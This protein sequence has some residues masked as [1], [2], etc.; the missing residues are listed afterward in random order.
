MRILQSKIAWL[1]FLT[2]IFLAGIGS[3][4]PCAH[5]RPA[6]LEDAPY[7]VLE[8]RVQIT[9]DRQGRSKVRTDITWEI[10]KEEARSLFS[11][12]RFVYNSRASRFRIIRAEAFAPGSHRSVAVPAHLIQD[13]PLASAR[14][15]F[16]QQNQVSVAFP[17]IEKGSQIHIQYEENHT[18]PP[19]PGSFSK[20]FILGLGELTEKTEIEISSPHL[21]LYSAIHDPEGSLVIHQNTN[22]RIHLSLKKPVFFQPME[23]PESLIEGSQLIWV[24][25]SSH[26]SWAPMLQSTLPAYEARLRDPLPSSLKEILVLLAKDEK[27]KIPGVDQVNLLMA[28]LSTQFHYFGDWRPIR[29]GHIP[30]PLKT[31][32]ETRFGDCKDLSLALAALLRELGYSAHLAWIQR[33]SRPVFSPHSLPI[34]GAFN[35]AIVYAQKDGR[36]FWLDPTNR[37]SFA[38]GVFEDI[39]DRPAL[40]LD[41]AQP[42]LVRTP[43]ALA[44]GSQVEFRSEVRTQREDTVTR[45]ELDLQGR[46]VLPY[47][48]EELIRSQENISYRLVSRFA[49]ESRLAEWKV[50]PYSL[51]ERIARP[52]SFSFGFKEMGVDLQTSEGSAQVLPMAPGIRKFLV[53]SRDRISGLSVGYPLTWVSQTQV[54]GAKSEGV[55]QGCEIRS[56]WA[57]LVRSYKRGKSDARVIQVSD[58]VELLQSKVSLDELRSEPYAR[59]RTQVRNCFDRKALI[60]EEP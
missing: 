60:V 2:V 37:V 16:D 57:N 29:G 56:P 32:A 6:R 27:G 38:E 47:A 45:V 20:S 22:R 49:D 24:D 17:S 12:K 36:E 52:L 21:P 31:I 25:V 11:Q 9:V 1:G 40:I 48:G 39:I 33:S 53:E 51:K 15:G 58:R 7:R 55:L 13:K 59:F 8:E 10:L 28:L 46:A 34:Q 23:E 54:F 50:E 26:L 14:S 35:H 43:A 42:R 19:L 5:A 30:R 4:T 18:E 41:P 44:Q 3:W